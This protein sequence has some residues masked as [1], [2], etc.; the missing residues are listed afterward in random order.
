MRLRDRGDD[1]KTEA[2]SFRF[3]GDERT[4]LFVEPLLRD[5]GGVV[6]EAHDD[7]PIFRFPANP[8]EGGAGKFGS[9]GAGLGFHGVSNEIDERRFEFER[10][11]PHGDV[12]PFDRNWDFLR[13][14][15][16]CGRLADDFAE[17][18]K[19]VAPFFALCVVSNLLDDGVHARNKR[20][21]A[22]KAKAL[23]ARP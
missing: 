18:E 20:L 11:A 22:F 16:F 2:Q 9:I 8:Q 12:V 4:V 15:A 21:A 19:G 13:Y 10:T 1:L 7:V 14:A 3:F 17:I 5:E 6:F 23:L